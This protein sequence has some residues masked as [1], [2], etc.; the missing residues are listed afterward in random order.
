MEQLPPRP[1]H[2]RPGAP[3]FAPLFGARLRPLWGLVLP[4]MCPALKPACGRA[5]PRGPGFKR[6]SAALRGGSTRSAAARPALC[7]GTLRLRIRPGGR[8]QPY[9]KYAPH[10]PPPLSKWGQGGRGAPRHGYERRKAAS[11][12]KRKSRGPLP[13]EGKRSQPGSF[14]SPRKRASR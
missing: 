4:K 9:R 14:F 12:R 13:Y 2:P 11:P 1:R 5:S 8:A 7:S 6:C 3:L 10:P